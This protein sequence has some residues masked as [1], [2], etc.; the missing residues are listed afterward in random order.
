MSSQPKGKEDERYNYNTSMS[1]S[2]DINPDVSLQL[3]LSVADQASTSII[4]ELLLQ[5]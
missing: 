3:C 1:F 4:V 2:D 5:T